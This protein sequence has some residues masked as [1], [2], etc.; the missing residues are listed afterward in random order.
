MV[1]SYSDDDDSDNGGVLR[2]NY[3]YSNNGGYTHNVA[4]RDTN[5]GTTHNDGIV[6]DISHGIEVGPAIAA[7]IAIIC[8]LALTTCGYKLL[9]PAMF[10]C[11]FLVGGFIVSSIV[12]YIV[13][14][15]SYERLAFWIAFVIGGVVLGSLVVFIYN[16]G[17]FLI[18]AAGGVFLATLLNASFGYRLYPNDPSSGLFIMAIVLGLIC[19]I[20]AYKVE[21]LAIIVATALVG[22]VVLVNGVGYFIGDFPELTGIE[23]YRHKDE[24]GDFV[25]DVPKAWWG[26]LAAMLVVFCLGIVIQIKKTGK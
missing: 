22:S 10:V 6:G 17:V 5:T 2:G 26:Y 25:Y 8:G 11:G 1:L 4:V 23:N 19:G 12:L 16:L 9:R 24:K 13:D 14:G 18:G 15:Q 7:A 21:R 20:I 3:D